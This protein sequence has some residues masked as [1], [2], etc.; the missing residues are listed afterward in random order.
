ML[1]VVVAS[2]KFLILFLLR[3][4]NQNNDLTDVPAPLDAVYDVAYSD[5]RFAYTGEPEVRYSGGRGPQY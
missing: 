1:D 3:H 4:E 2:S 5:A